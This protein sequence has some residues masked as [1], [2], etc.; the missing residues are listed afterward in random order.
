MKI[1]WFTITSSLFEKNKHHYNGAG[2]IES[3]ESI[4]GNRSDVELAVAFYHPKLSTKVVRNNTSYYPIKFK[5]KRHAPIKAIFDN[6]RGQIDYLGLESRYIEIINDFQP[7]VIHVFGTESSYAVVSS[8][9]SIPVVLQTQ[10]LMNPI[11]NTFFPV[12]QSK[13]SFYGD[14]RYLLSNFLGFTL[15]FVK[16][17]YENI[18][19]V[20]SEVLK[21]SKFVI[22]RTNWDKMV[23]KL[24]NPEVK[25][26]HVDEVLRSIFYQ[27]QSIEPQNRGDVLRI[28]S[29]LSPTIY[30]GIDVVLKTAKLL[31]EKTN[32]KFIWEIIGLQ[33][34][35]KL[36]KHFQRTEG[37]CHKEVGIKLC[38]SMNAEQVSDKLC[39]SN[40]YIHPSYI[41]NSPN[42]ICEAQIKGIPVI[43]CNVGG[44]SS[45]ISHLTDGILVPSNGIYELASYIVELNSNLELAKK[46][47]L[48]GKNRALMRHD[49][50]KIENDLLKVYNYLNNNNTKSS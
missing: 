23:V 29:T 16:I 15:P 2:W 45:L 30:K 41:D 39:E 27:N 35:T 11:V 33:E 1:L 47:S 25:Y 6:R 37:I 34:D 24:Y 14:I 4:I 13:W 18:A 50:T 40:I 46:L 38:G 21:Q 7:D 8:L 42:S 5:R 10:G 17:K 9:T 20:E 44:V 31:S 32:L 36:L 19:K 28:I 12:N 26:F 43:A 48:N 22:G 3:L 49:K